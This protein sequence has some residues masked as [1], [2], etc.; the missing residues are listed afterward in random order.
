MCQTQFL[1]S[2]KG[3]CGLG[4]APGLKDTV[5]VCFMEELLTGTLPLPD[6]GV[7]LISKDIVMRAASGTDTAGGF[8]SMLVSRKKS[9]YVS[10]TKGEDGS[11][12]FEPEMEVFVERQD[13]NKAFVLKQTNGARL[14]VIFT[15]NNGKQRV[16][17]H[18]SLQ[19][20]SMTDPEN[21]YMLKFTASV[22]PEEPYFYTGAITI[23]A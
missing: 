18:A 21:G 16:M 15:D 8:V 13:E 17:D 14:C 22:Q 1:K 12:Y 3:H 5:F 6:D 4:N 2:L 20:Q 7:H 19:Y 23:R 9:K 10:N 11:N